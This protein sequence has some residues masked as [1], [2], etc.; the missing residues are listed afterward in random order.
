MLENNKPLD[1]LEFIFKYSTDNSILPILWV[2]DKG[3]IIYYNKSV[4]EYIGNEDLIGTYVYRL[5]SD[6]TED[7]WIKIWNILKKNNTYKF[8]YEFY[9]KIKDKIFILD[10]N[11]IKV[12]YNNKDY[13]YMSIIDITELVE[14][15]N[16]LLK[17]KDRA[18]ESDRLKN[19]FLSNMSHE[20]R[21]PMNAIVGFSEI[22]DDNIDDYL[23]EYTKIILTN[24]EYLLSLID[25]IITISRIDSEQIRIKKTPF[26]MY[27]LMNNIHMFYSNKIGK[28]TR[29]INLILDNDDDDDIIIS[30]RYIIDEC[31]HMLISNSIKFSN[32]G[33]INIGYKV[34]NNNIIVYVKD[35]GI[36]IQNKYH[37]IIFDRFRQIN[38]Q[39]IGS[40]LGLSIFK[41]YMKMLNGKY[42][43]NSIVNK[44]TSISFELDIDNIKKKVDKTLIKNSELKRLKNKKILIAE[45]IEI[46]QLLL[47]DMLVPYGVN[48]IKCM[49][50]NEC[51]EKFTEIKDIDLIL[52]DLDMPYLDGY[53][54]TEIIR[55]TDKVI[56]IIAQTAYSQKENR[57]KARRIG[58]TDFIKK[59]LIKDD[60]LKIIIMYI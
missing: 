38:K 54:T 6:I 49:D 39:T 42:T 20:I 5:A 12:T 31:L 10:V 41:S 8:T 58:F 9:D 36:G 47:H 28:L 13:C 40:G 3:E 33:D 44:G 25:N 57:E 35:N 1:R 11:T 53:E 18:E 15:N 50:G 30:D 23:K 59:P 26:N 60:I 4:S 37:E 2:N 19:A 45:D 51:I 43:L 52:M 14:T 7:N 46:N 48:I 16:K 32:D 21:T 55:D 22:L 24:V 17:E 34:Q 27:D 56:P 29:N